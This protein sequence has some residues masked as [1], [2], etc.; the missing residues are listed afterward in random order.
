M[1]ATRALADL[2]EISSQVR[3]AVVF[4]A[5][6]GIAASTLDAD[7]RSQELVRAATELL[8]AAEAFARD[9]DCRGVYVDTPVDNEAG[10]GFYEAR[11]YR[12]DYRMSRYYADDLDGVTYVKFFN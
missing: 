4:D 6:G 12:E 11:G 2:T 8:E 1:D 3:A 10:R 9:R 7:D 5:Q